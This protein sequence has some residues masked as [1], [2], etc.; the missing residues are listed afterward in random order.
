MLLEEGKQLLGGAVNGQTPGVHALSLYGGGGGEKGGVKGGA[1]GA[2]GGGGGGGATG[3]RGAWSFC[4][5]GQLVMGGANG[6]A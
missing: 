3:E 1:G 6:R 5:R 4:G 2:R